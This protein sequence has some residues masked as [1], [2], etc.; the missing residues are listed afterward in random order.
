MDKRFPGP[1]KIQ[2]F[3]LAN[4]L[5]VLAYENFSS[6]SVVINGLLRVGALQDPPAQAGLADFTSEL[7]MRGTESQ[8][9][10]QIY[11]RLESSGVSLGLGAGRHVTHFSGAALAED[12]DLMLEILADALRQPLF[13]P[14]HIERVRGQIQTGLQMRAN[15]TQQ[16][17]ALSFMETLYAQHPYGRSLHGY[18]QTVANITREDMVNFHADY[19]GP[20]GMIIAVVGAVKVAD[21]HK[22]ITSFLGDW[23]NPGQK[24]FPAIPDARRPEQLTRVNVPMPEKAQADIVMGLP[25]P[26]RNAGDYLHA[27]M[28]NTILGVFGMMGRIGRIIREEQGLAYH[29]SSNLSGGL[30]PTPWT[31]SAGV[32]P[33]NVEKAIRGIL[34]EI[35]KIRNEPVA[36]VELD[37]AKSYRIGSLP[38]SLETNASL[39]SIFVDLDLYDLGLDY[40]QRVPAIIREIT[41]DDV[42]AAAQKYLS[43]EQLVVA[44]AGPG[45]WSG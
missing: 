23:Q 9:F 5:K 38:V 14:E 17:A 15:D 35:E 41:I 1:E 45:N 26:R 13:P 43:S 31:A 24:P 8:N 44:V 12:L 21:I 34:G 40:L 27:S 30:G 20:T 10:D 19:Y 37:D 16:M 42:Q 39:A 7:L 18:P 36:V 11:E 25:G 28:M 2:R 4:G 32:A 6:Q 33:D 22:K 3:F 29:A